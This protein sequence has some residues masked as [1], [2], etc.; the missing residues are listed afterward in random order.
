MTDKNLIIRDVTV[1][2]V[3]I[4][5]KRPIVARIAQFTHWV[6]VVVD[7]E[8]EGEVRGRGYICPYLT[9]TAAAFGRVA[10]IVSVLGGLVA[11]WDTFA[12]A[13]DMPLAVALGAEIA[14]VKA[15]NSCG[16]WLKDPAELAEEA[17][18]LRDQH[19]FTAVKVRFARSTIAEDVAAA[20]NVIS[21]IPGT[22]VMSDFNQ[23]LSYSEAVNHLRALDDE[24]GS[25]GLRNRL[26]IAT[27]RAV[28]GCQRK[29][30]YR[31]CWVKISTVR[32]I[33]MKP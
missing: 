10:K 22:I 11:L 29:C 4:P 18:E 26:S 27:W 20:R 32:A 8:T 7:I 5:L 9:G 14:P 24:G 31:L 19:D 12:K 21:A 17:V 15:Y 6:A 13:H 2:A 28:R 30:A 1:R 25:I 23:S 33:C 3:I 16:L